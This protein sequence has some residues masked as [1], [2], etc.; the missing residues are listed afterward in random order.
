MQRAAVITATGRRGG[1][2][3]A[4]GGVFGDAG[5]GEVGDG[6]VGVVLRVRVRLRLGFGFG[7]LAVGF[8]GAGG[9]AEEDVGEGGVGAEGEGGEGVGGGGGEGLEAGGR[10]RRLRVSTVGGGT[11]SSTL[12]PSIRPSLT[13]TVAARVERRMVSAC[14]RRQSAGRVGRRRHL[15]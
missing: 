12:L 3:V 14:L 5:R 7:E 1:A 8:E 9:G 6:A 13:R 15:A 10:Q 2:G 11:D 4:A